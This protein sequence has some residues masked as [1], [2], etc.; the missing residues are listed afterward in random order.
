MQFL[1]FQPELILNMLDGILEQTYSFNLGD[2]KNELLFTVLYCYCLK[3]FLHIKILISRGSKPD[4]SLKIAS[5]PGE[6]CSL[7]I[8]LESKQIKDLYSGKSSGSCLII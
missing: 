7:V 8:P 4:E 6:A 1:L 5:C 3:P 2:K